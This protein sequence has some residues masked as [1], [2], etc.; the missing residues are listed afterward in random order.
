MVERGRVLA[1]L[2]ALLLLTG[3]SAFAQARVGDTWQARIESPHPVEGKVWRQEVRIPGSSF[4]KFHLDTLQ[5]GPD[6]LFLVYGADGRE[7]FAHVGPMADPS[8]LPSVD[9]PTATLEIWLEG[10]SQSWGLVV[11]Q[12]AFGDPAKYGPSPAPESICGASDLKDPSCYDAGMQAAGDA[13]GRMLFQGA[14]GGVYACTGSLVSPYNHVLTNNHCI[15][16]E[17]EAQSLEMRWRYQ[18]SDCGS[19]SVATESTSVGADLVRTDHE[20]DYTLLHL[21]ADAPADRYG[22]LT[23]S[24][25]KA[26]KGDTIWIPQHPLGGPKKFAVTSDLDGGDCTIDKVRLDGYGRRT[27][28]GYYADT[29]PGSSGS[30]VI[31]ANGEVTALHHFGTGTDSCDKHT[32]NQGVRMDRIYRDVGGYLGVPQVTSMRKV[33]NPFRIIVEGR[34]FSPDVKVFI[35]G[36]E[37]TEVKVKNEH[38]I[39]LKKGAT[40]KAAVPKNTATDFQFSN[41]YVPEGPVITWQWP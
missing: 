8:W 38:K 22:Y 34:H 1:A 37:W 21:S 40:L 28:V 14:D 4:V 16:T 39:V 12:V 19:G 20:L 29:E 17:A 35:D 2:S 24:D 26:R 31:A 18:Y 32:M 5:I 25:A 23:L 7:A 30:P 33:G 41:P 36:Q 3:L 6:D 11:D 13:V 10:A 9:G 15:A 27:D